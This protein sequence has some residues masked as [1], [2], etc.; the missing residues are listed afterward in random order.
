[1]EGIDHYPIILSIENHATEEN[2]EKMLHILTTRFH[3]NLY[4]VDENA[5]TFPTLKKLKGK[6]VIKTSSNE[7]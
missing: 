6:I 4:Y 2:R 7:K 1:M 3:N 5:K